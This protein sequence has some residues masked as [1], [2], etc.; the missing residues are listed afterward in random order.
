M[1]VFVCLC[2]AADCTSVN[3]SVNAMK[4]DIVRRIDPLLDGLSTGDITPIISYQP[5]RLHPPRTDT[6]I[7]SQSPYLAVARHTRGCLSE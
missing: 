5:E 1:R 3:Q 4:R 2:A 7:E 6:Q